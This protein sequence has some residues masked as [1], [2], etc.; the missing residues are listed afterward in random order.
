MEDQS[1]NKGPKPV[2]FK[3]HRWLKWRLFLQFK[4]VLGIIMASGCFLCSRSEIK[5]AGACTD[6]V[7]LIVLIE[8]RGRVSQ[9]GLR[10]AKFCHYVFIDVMMA[11]CRSN[12][13]N[14]LLHHRVSFEA[15]SPLLRVVSWRQMACI[16]WVCL[17][18]VTK[19][20][21]R[22]IINAYPTMK[23][24]LQTYMACVCN[25]FILHAD[26]TMTY[27][28][29]CTQTYSQYMQCIYIVYKHHKYTYAHRLAHTHGGQPFRNRIHHTQA[30]ILYT[31][32]V[33]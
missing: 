14:D 27:R 8:V 17:I 19:L 7:Q 2:V 29:Y 16:T 20:V 24:M 31:L 33:T 13:Y 18:C 25:R 28:T 3:Q 15:S 5:V 1:I 4:L 21:P 10:F 23:Y 11:C 9:H 22:V 6:R 30:V 12:G 26:I 32:Y